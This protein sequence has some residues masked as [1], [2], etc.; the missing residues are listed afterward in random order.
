MQ[1]SLRGETREMGFLGRVGRW[2]GP[3]EGAPR[4]KTHSEKSLAAKLTSQTRRKDL[5]LGAAI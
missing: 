4:D 2:R 3:R 5:A 1:S